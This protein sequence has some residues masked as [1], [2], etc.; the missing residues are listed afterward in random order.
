MYVIFVVRLYTIIYVIIA[1]DKPYQTGYKL[2]FSKVSFSAGKSFN[3][4]DAYKKET[5]YICNFESYKKYIFM[6]TPVTLIY[7]LFYIGVQR[8]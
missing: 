3:Q 2:N 4:V 8:H 6:Y 5:S 1:E 7:A